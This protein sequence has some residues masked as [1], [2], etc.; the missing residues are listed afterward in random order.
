[1]AQIVTRIRVMRIDFEGA[2]VIG[3]RLVDAARLV[4]RIAAV[5]ECEV[6]A[7]RYA[8]RVVEKRE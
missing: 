5:V 1:V 3:H 6:I 7:A 8:H 4:K 2:P